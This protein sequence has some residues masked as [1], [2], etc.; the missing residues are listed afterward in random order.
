MQR[1]VPA[2]TFLIWWSLDFSFWIKKIC[3]SAMHWVNSWNKLL[4]YNSIV[5]KWYQRLDDKSVWNVSSFR[6]KFSID[7]SFSGM[8][9]RYSIKSK[10]NIN[11]WTKKASQ[12]DFMKGTL[13]I[14]GTFRRTFG[15]DSVVQVII[16]VHLLNK[17]NQ[18]VNG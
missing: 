17:G 3:D 13:K 14:P 8:W 12:K 18:R 11:T 9:K 4:L 1:C 16:L 7:L 10:D 5:S 15:L 2:I 6:T